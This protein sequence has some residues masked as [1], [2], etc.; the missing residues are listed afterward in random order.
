MGTKYRSSVGKCISCVYWS[1]RRQTTNNGK[2][3]VVESLERGVCV[4]PTSRFKHVNNKDRIQNCDGW[5]SLKG[6]VLFQEKE[7][8]EKE[9]MKTNEVK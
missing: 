4:L 7:N 8:Q 1:G 2:F 6:N 5:A 9:N 3:A